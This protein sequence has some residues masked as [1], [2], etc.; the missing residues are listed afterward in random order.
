MARSIWSG[1][2][3]FGLIAIPVKLFTAVRHK[4]VSFNQLDDRNMSRIRYLK[5]SEETGEE[6]P[7]EQ[8]IKGVEISK[9]R[10]VIVDPDELAPFVPLATKTIEVE[11]FVN[12]AEI[13]PIYFETSYYVA[14]HLTTKPYVL[15]AK[16]LESAGKVAIVRFV[17]RS[18]QYT[19][20]LRA[21]EGR[22]V[23]STLAYADE[24][25]PVDEVE[26]LAGLDTVDVS[27]REVKMAE[28]LVES[29]SAEFAPDKY[30]DDYRIQVLD[31]IGRKAAG[32]EFE[33]PAVEAQKPKIVDMMAALEAS[34]EAAKAARGRHPTAREAP[35]AAAKK[36][37]KRAAK[38]RVRKTA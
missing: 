20:A 15:L 24:I 14:P 37:A 25:V 38:P 35:D 18:R 23:L 4:G 17:M 10:Y 36:P 21:D 11:E 22:L 28:M 34:V 26:D 29:L 31:L 3:S 13:D 32:E 6:V 7:S 5:V 27:D 30:Q 12:L 16:A 8:I 1:T 33:L 19:A 2:I 9:G